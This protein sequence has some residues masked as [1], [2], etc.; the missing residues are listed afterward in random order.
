MDRERWPGRT[1]LA[2]ATRGP[3]LRPTVPQGPTINL[4]QLLGYPGAV[5]VTIAGLP[6]RCRGPDRLRRRAAHADEP[7]EAP[8]TAPSSEA[9]A[10]SEGPARNHVLAGVPGLPIGDPGSDLAFPTLAP[11]YG[12]LG[13]VG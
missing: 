2:N 9:T 10:D 3:H 4:G 1:A 6:R 5:V 8:A 7:D 12:A 13:S 11:V